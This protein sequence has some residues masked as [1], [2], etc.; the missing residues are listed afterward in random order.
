MQ[1]LSFLL[2]FV[3]AC[4]VHAV[5]INAAHVPF[6]ICIIFFKIYNHYAFFML[7]TKTLFRNVIQS[8]SR[9]ALTSKGDVDLIFYHPSGEASFF[10][11]NTT[12][13]HSDRRCFLYWLPLHS[14]PKLQSHHTCFSRL[15]SH[16]ADIKP[17]FNTC[18]RI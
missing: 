2:H 5:V 1:V 6:L 14:P 13:R 11:N 8:V 16:C 18:Y 4:F 7:S 12:H 10:I 17:I 9:G 15:Q 3:S